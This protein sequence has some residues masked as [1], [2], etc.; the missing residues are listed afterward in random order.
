MLANV[1]NSERAIAM[2][3]QVVREFIRLRSIARSDC[4]LKETLQQLEKAVNSRLNRH[5]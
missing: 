2:S 1:L 4:A 3:V 5:E